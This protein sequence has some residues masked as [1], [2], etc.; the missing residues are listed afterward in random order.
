MTKRIILAHIKF[1][2][3]FKWFMDKEIL[4]TKHKT[5]IQYLSERTATLAYKRVL[6]KG[7]K[8]LLEKHGFRVNVSRDYVYFNIPSNSDSLC[9]KIRGETFKKIST[10]YYYS[11]YSSRS[12]EVNITNY[13]LRASTITEFLDNVYDDIKKL[14]KIVEAKPLPKKER[15]VTPRKTKTQIEEIKNKEQILFEKA[16]K[17]QNNG[18]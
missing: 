13:S 14:S 9:R 2:E 10:N 11:R 12:G 6:K 7:I 4:K 1:L 18:R 5:P 8:L 3:M 15:I 16:W 17:G